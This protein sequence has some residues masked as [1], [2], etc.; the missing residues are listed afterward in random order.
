MIPLD[1]RSATAA[2][3]WLSSDASRKSFGSLT[4]AYVRPSGLSRSLCSSGIEDIS[5][6]P[7]P[8]R[9]PFLGPWLPCIV[10]GY[11][12]IRNS[13]RELVNTLF[14]HSHNDLHLAIGRDRHFATLGGADD[15]IVADAE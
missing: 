12:G 6:N 3:S 8:R 11:L 5:K 2:S 14:S 7:C 9:R 1:S 13:I 4:R 15:L 10:H